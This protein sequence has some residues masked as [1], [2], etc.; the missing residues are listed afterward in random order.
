MPPSSSLQSFYVNRF[1]FDHACSEQQE[2]NHITASRTGRDLAKGYRP[3]F[4]T[5]YGLLIDSR[6]FEIFM[7]NIGVRDV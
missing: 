6:M 5:R 7:G 2:K 3:G 4:R 1:D